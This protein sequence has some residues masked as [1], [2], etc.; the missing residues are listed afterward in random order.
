MAYE[1]FRQI[2]ELYNAVIDV[3]KERRISFLKNACGDD[4][5]LR[6]EVQSLLAFADSKD[7]LFDRPPEDLAAE[8][9]SE[10]KAPAS[11]LNRTIGRYK[12]LGV[13]GEGGMGTVY[14]ARDDRLAR[15]VALKVLPAEM[16]RQKDRVQRFIH[17]AR[18]A[19]ALNHP[20][21][22]TVYEI[23]EVEQAELGK[24]HFI[25]MEL[26][27]GKTL[28]DLIH[29]AD[30]ST[31]D[32]L[33]YLAQTAEGLAK[34]HAAGI[35]HRDLKPDN[36]MVSSDGYAKILD[37]GL[38]KLTNPEHELNKL[39]QH[40]STPGLILGTLG[41]MSP[42]QAQGKSEIDARS[43][44][45]S[46]GCIL[47]EAVTRSKAFASGSTIDALHKII[48]SEPAPIADLVP[49]TPDDL[50]GLIYE[51]LNKDPDQRPRR[52]EDIVPIL[53]QLSE[54]DLS[55]MNAPP[56]TAEPIS[57]INEFA[58][59]QPTISR[60]F[61]EERRQVTVMYADASA[62]LELFEDSEPEQAS[63]I[64][65]NLWSYVEGVISKGGGKIGEHLS[66][67]FV[68]AW[69]A[70][71][72]RERDA[73][74]AVRTGLELHA[75][76]KVYFKN[77]ILTSLDISE[78][79]R[80][81]LEDVDFLRIGISTGTVLLG[82][83]ADSGEF[84]TTGS[85]V[86]AAKRLRTECSLG[87]ILVSH[88]TYR[89]I[90][91][92][93]D[94]EAISSQRRFTFRNK[95]Q[96]T[97]VYSVK[98]IKPRAFRLETR[99]VEGIETEMV[100]REAELAKLL[101]SLE[102]VL[103][104]G[105]FQI[106]TVVGEA[107]LGKS[108]LLFEFQDQAELLKDEFY[109]FKARGLDTVRGMPY[110]LIRDLFSFRF[111]IQESDS[112]QIARDKFV[113]G[114]AE[115]TAG[116]RRIFGGR[117]EAEMK[118]HF[119]GHLLG[120]DFA[121]SPHV[122]AVSGD[123][124]QL[125]D[126]ALS[127]ATQFFSA[128]AGRRPLVIYLDDLHW[129]DDESLNFINLIARECVRSPILIAEFARPGLFERRPNWGEGQLNRI[130]LRLQPLTKRESRR[131]IR[132]IL[133]KS[134]DI[135]KE[136]HDLLISNTDGN[137]FFIEELVKMLIEEGVI[138]TAGENWNIDAKRLGEISVPTT[139]TG[140]L[141][142]RLDRLAVWEKR[143]LQRASVIGRE[144]WDLAL[145]GFGRDVNIPTVLESLCRKELLF[146]REFS[147][148]DN[149][150]EYI[151]K[152]ALLREVTYGTVILDDRR[153]WHSETAGWLITHD[154]QRENDHLDLIAGHFEKANELGRSA[155]W[156]G[157][158][159][160]QALSSFALDVAVGYFE[161]ALGFWKISADQDRSAE[162][163]DK[164]LRRWKLGLGKAIVR[165]AKYPEAIRIF[166]EV[167]D[168]AQKADDRLDR[169]KA[170]EGISIAQ[171]ENGEPRNSLENSRETIRLAA[172][173]ESDP[174]DEKPALLS[175]GWYR[176]GRAHLSLGDFDETIKCAEKTLEI[177]ETMGAEGLPARVNSFH[178][179][180]SAL[181]YS[182][183]I[184]EAKEYEKRE[185]EIARRIG[186]LTSVANGLNSLGFQSYMLGD[187]KAALEYYDE[188]GQIAREIGNKS[189]ELMIRSNAG[190]ARVYLGEYAAA[191]NELRSLIAETGD[192]GYF[193][194]PETYRFLA[195][196]LIGQGKYPE[197]LEAAAKSYRLSKESESREM[198]A[199]ALRVLGVV[200]ASLKSDV[201]IDDRRCSAA[202]CFE[203]SL[204]ILKST[205]MEA[206]RAQV[207]HNFARLK[208]IEGDEEKSRELL[209]ESDEISNRLKIDTA[210]KGIYFR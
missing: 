74:Q 105:E 31:N 82:H 2:E 161:K 72:V 79:E 11:L 73:E 3:P 33:R 205:G 56:L 122:T 149:A 125:Q 86:N 203:N 38:A 184:A 70:E 85:P 78:S 7:T 164:Q 62:V 111:E 34:G 96:N 158:A 65:R 66:G 107:G 103:K 5:E 186:N 8:V 93:F 48:H 179:L 147:T 87:E 140:V 180:G 182:G 57:A 92:V 55:G 173:L 25:S 46:F 128:V 21:I 157:R 32:L 13:L 43:D 206:N 27:V 169:V 204:E 113:A 198:I 104:D 1:R 175:S 159:G 67:I 166:R 139:P 18:A 6:K 137:P 63:L 35:V 69:G 64:M 47:Y 123:E 172:E 144:F 94:I 168:E 75:G 136:L 167:L 59:T 42:E 114:V 10:R 108:R 121:D 200:S 52:I 209:A 51:C 133:Q 189:S 106:V 160:E 130:R 134:D 40:R 195:E 100:G 141:Q 22:L 89:H 95:K 84:V 185:V 19:S 126:R 29:S 49:G 138:S 90:R 12:I 115:L 151:F 124:K 9:L 176:M 152:H 194:V 39:R 153:R 162:I 163:T 146:R 192:Y 15:S 71:A 91:G 17:E 127:Y 135:P 183:R 24:I 202:E 119:I 44:I 76:L 171:F 53:R 181:M 150:N 197:A 148:F 81:T 116:A 16:V 170:Y 101:D 117:E 50:K 112:R 41:Y 30:V 191:E 26:V 109:V 120:F 4:E 132:D 131:L 110:S 174:N 193:L 60:Q 178:L 177:A 187:G 68:A 28:Q 36:I 199:E 80:K 155:E 190:G 143:V 14:L 20:N 129:A 98:G 77:E 83:D 210:A 88:D 188:A 156:Y 207:L 165:R 58:A 23:D 118:A 142:S 45:F 154:G 97:K 208:E 54:S 201:E 145:T 99:G 61:S 102:G 196:A 37:F